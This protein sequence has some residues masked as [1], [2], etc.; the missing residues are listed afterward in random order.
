LVA[1]GSGDSL[2]TLEHEHS[3]ETGQSAA[4]IAPAQS[5]DTGAAPFAPTAPPIA[6]DGTAMPTKP[7]ARPADAAWTR[8]DRY[9]TQAQARMLREA[10]GDGVFELRV[11]C[12]GIEAV[13]VAVGITWGM[14]A[15]GLIDA[16]PVLVHGSDLCLAAAAVNRLIEGGL[17]EVWL[18]TR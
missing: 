2:A 16:R 6:D 4:A 17:T 11:E 1:C 14:Q 13:V 5:A 12:C 8:N 10:L 7:R 9:A 3:A 15:A 18:V